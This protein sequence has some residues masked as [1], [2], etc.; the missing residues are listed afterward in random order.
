MPATALLFNGTGEVC[1]VHVGAEAVPADH[2]VLTSGGFGGS[3]ELLSR[4]WPEAVANGDWHWYLGPETRLT[5]VN[6]DRQR[7]I[8]ETDSYCVIGDV[9][10]RT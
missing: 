7:F 5:Y 1:G 4:Y 6:L 9:I 2:V 10:A 8:S 3:H